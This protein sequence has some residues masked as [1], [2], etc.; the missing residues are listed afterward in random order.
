MS[1]RHNILP[2]RTSFFISSAGKIESVQEFKIFQATF[3]VFQNFSSSCFIASDI[4]VKIIW[5]HVVVFS[6]HMFCIFEMFIC[7]NI[8]Q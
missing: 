3:P 8:I 1:K 4:H 7:L 6:E 2:T 5:L